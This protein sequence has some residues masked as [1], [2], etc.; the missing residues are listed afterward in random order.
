MGDSAQSRRAPTKRRAAS[1]RQ[2]GRS[3]RCRLPISSPSGPTA[4]RTLRATE[5]AVVDRLYRSAFSAAREGLGRT[6]E[7]VAH[8]IHPALA[9]APDGNARTVV[10]RAVQAAA[11][12]NG[13]LIEVD[14]GG[15]LRAIGQG[16]LLQLIDQ[17]WQ[18]V[19]SAVQPRYSA[20]ATLAATGLT[21]TECHDLGGSDV[22][23][24]RSAVSTGRREFQVPAAG[25]KCLVAQHIVR[26]LAGYQ[27]D[28]PY[29]A[30]GSRQAV[31]AIAKVL[32]TM[33]E[34]LGIPLRMRSSR[35][36]SSPHWQYRWGV[37]IKW[38]GKP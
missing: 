35:D 26:R 24:D 9:S 21:P 33:T 1:L 23:E 29:L 28:D 8:D 36:R 31:R 32:N 20:I 5:F 3:R 11:F 13:M 19:A 15:V 2:T 14:V 25:R 37:Q 38:L 17:D 12:A 6:E 30:D 27:A 16:D 10:L 18:K 7:S 4:Q 22:A 34:Q